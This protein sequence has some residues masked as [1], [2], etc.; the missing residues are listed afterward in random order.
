MTEAS[1]ERLA[2]LDVFRGLTIAGMILVNN[3][4]SWSS[5]YP[6]LRHAAWNGCTPTDLVFPFFLF[7]VGVAITLSLS[8]RKERG[9]DKGTLV[10][11]ILTRTFLI[12]F[13]GLFLHALPRFDFAT[14]RIPGV[15]A[16]IAVV[17]GI[18]AILFLTTSTRTQIAV[19]LACL[20]GYWGLMTLIPVP[21][22]GAANLNV[23]TNLAAW[24]D[25]WLLGGHL[26]GQT[27]TWD[28][29]GPLST[30]PA[31]GTC[32]A[33]LML[34]HWLRTRNDSAVKTSWIMVAGA[35]AAVVGVIWDI[36]FPINKSIWTSSYVMYV[37]GLAA[38][39]FGTI[40]WLVDVR[41]ITWF[42]KPFTVLGRNAIAAYVF[43]WLL[44]TAM[45]EITVTGAEGTTVPLGTY[46]YAGF[47]TPYFSP[48]NAS[49][50]WAVCTV[51]VSLGVMWIL[52]S[53]KIF[54]RL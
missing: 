27:K 23:G 2:S 22:V 20:F 50:A 39:F 37:G 11:K 5:V 15:L 34:G 21:G 32:I 35:L 1:Q 14:L 19:G 28:P 17:Y 46:L 18:T 38:M 44:E 47:F 33:G 51:L 10:R 49:L 29:E 4:G 36:W 42:T 13:V 7:I 16:R 45:W 8:K 40:Y 53:R 48:L 25:N 31:V 26:W 3:P 54:I 6:A 30:I 12:F 41:K 52:S 9:D 24:F 43:A